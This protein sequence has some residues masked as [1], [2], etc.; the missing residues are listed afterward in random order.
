MLLALCQSGPGSLTKG[1]EISHP[2]SGNLSVSTR[3]AMALQKRQPDCLALGSPQSFFYLLPEWISLLT[4]PF[5]SLANNCY[6]GSLGVKLHILQHNAEYKMGVGV[7]REG[8]ILVN[9][10]IRAGIW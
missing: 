6:P 9:D 10:N 2:H 7:G 4:M 8:E 5:P 3:K 1:V